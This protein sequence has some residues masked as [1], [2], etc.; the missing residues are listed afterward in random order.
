M[1]QSLAHTFVGC[2]V[3]CVPLFKTLSVPAD[4]VRDNGTQAQSLADTF[5]AW[6][7]HWKCSVVQN[8]TMVKSSKLLCVGTFA[9]S[10]SFKRVRRVSVPIEDNDKHICV[11]VLTIQNT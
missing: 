5:A 8:R 2:Y 6:H 3:G 7:W 11:L 1:V 9:T 10:G 4:Y